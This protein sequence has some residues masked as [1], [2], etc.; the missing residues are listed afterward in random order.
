[1]N[2]I[3]SALDRTMNTYTWMGLRGDQERRQQLRGTVR[4]VI[5]GMFENGQHNEE[6]LVVGALKYLVSLESRPLSTSVRER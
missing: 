3:S 5:E 2:A 4:T 1:M 6:R